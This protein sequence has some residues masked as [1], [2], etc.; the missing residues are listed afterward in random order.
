MNVSAC[1]KPVRL[2]EILYGYMIKIITSLFIP[3]I[4]LLAS[5]A[6]ALFE[7]D[8][9][10]VI[11]RA[12]LNIYF[13]YAEQDSSDFGVNDH[14]VTLEPSNI[15]SALNALQ[16]TEKKLFVSEQSRTVFSALQMNILAN[17]LS[18][19]LSEATPTQDVIFVMEG[20]RSKLILLT[21]KTF[22]A[23]RAFYQ[24]GKLNIILGEYDKAR[25]QAFESVY[26]PSG[27]AA[28]PYTFN[29]GRRDNNANVFEA[30]IENVDGF[31]HQR[32]NDKIRSDWLVIDI[33]KVA[34][35]YLAK[36]S[37]Q[38]PALQQNRDALGEA[39]KLAKERR[40]M[41]F[42]MARMR[43]EMKELSGGGRASDR[44]PE[45]RLVTLKGLYDKGLITEEE[46]TARRQA[47]LNNI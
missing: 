47:I 17:H 43:K 20:G 9:E 40:D 21:D 12:G 38:S 13:K 41:R 32:V 34:K 39:S 36:Q 10:D 3:L 18:A 16:F 14:P 35:A 45:R 1:C 29:H 26:D 42:E 37:Q 15:R 24:Q 7:N 4:V 28:I 11:W 22:V 19:G 31:A 44:S 25:N 30:K 6:Y 23:G 46:Y 27:R 33:K 5:H 8:D 2:F